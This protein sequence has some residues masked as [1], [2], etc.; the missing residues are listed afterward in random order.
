MAVLY[1][2]GVV[3]FGMGTK[4]LYCVVNGLTLREDSRYCP[5]GCCYK[6]DL[7]NSFITQGMNLPQTP[8][9]GSRLEV[10]AR[11]KQ[12]WTLEAS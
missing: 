8:H 5:C 7:R 2:R 6:S 12:V 4:R 3:K 9:L 10:E 11:F 1:L